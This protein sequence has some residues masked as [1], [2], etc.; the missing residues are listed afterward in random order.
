MLEVFILGV[1][2][3]IPEPKIKEIENGEILYIKLYRTLFFSAF[4]SDVN[5]GWQTNTSMS[6][7]LSFPGK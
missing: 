4:V 5:D 1:L 2:D 3:L 7:L 6:P